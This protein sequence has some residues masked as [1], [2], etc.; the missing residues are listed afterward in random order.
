[1]GC[2]SLLQ[3]IFLTQGSNSGLLHCR[4]IL[5][6]LSNQGSPYVTIPIVKYF[7]HGP[8]AQ[9]TFHTGF[10]SWPHFLDGIHE[11]DFPVLTLVP[12][13]NYSG[14]TLQLAALPL[15]WVTPLL[16][17][18][19]PW[20]PSFPGLTSGE[21]SHL[22]CLCQSQL[23]PSSWRKPAHS[24]SACI[25]TCGQENIW[26]LGQRLFSQGLFS[27]HVLQKEKLY[28]FIEEFQA[29]KAGGEEFWELKN[30]ES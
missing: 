7:D 27:F 20:E 12:V 10:L 4:Q 15:P 14:S 16:I 19:R 8:E 11:I 3:R 29:S 5:Y 22:S 23:A 30:L 6:H 24:L 21:H 18:P 25:K 9:L 28:S 26:I 1:M 13:K 17:Q 2:H